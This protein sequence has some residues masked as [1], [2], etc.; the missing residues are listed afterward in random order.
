MARMMRPVAD[1]LIGLL[2]GRVTGSN[3]AALPRGV[4]AGDLLR[5]A[6][7]VGRDDLMFFESAE[8]LIWQVARHE[9]YVIPDYPLAGNGEARKFL[10]EYGVEDLPSWYELRGVPRAK[11][12]RFWSYSAFMARDTRFWRKVIV[13]PKSDLSDASRLAPVVR[14]ALEFC[15]SDATGDDD[16]CLFS[17]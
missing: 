5:L 10:A 7:E 16:T 15:L 2:D 11:S 3:Q 9:G 8:M 1:K 4:T 6:L 13:F 12:A 17:I 14:D